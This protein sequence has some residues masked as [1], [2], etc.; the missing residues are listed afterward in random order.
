MRKSLFV[1][2]VFLLTASQALATSSVWKIQKGTSVFYLG[3]T[4]HLLRPTDFPPPKEFFQAFKASSIIVFETDIGKLK[5]PSMQQ[6][7]M[8][9]A[10]Y[11]DGSTL[12]NHISAATYQ[13]LK[14][15][16]ASHH[17][18]L[19][20]LMQYKP[21]ILAFTITFVELAKLGVTPEGVDTY[22]Y[23]LAQHDGKKVEGLETVER[24]IQLV[25]NMGQGNQDSFLLHTLEDMK[26]TAKRYDSMVDAWKK[27][28]V[29]KLDAS[30]IEDFRSQTPKLYRQ[31]LVYR[32][33]KWLPRIEALAKTPQTEFILVGVAHLV[34]PDGLL[35]ALQ[36][37]GYTIEPVQT[38]KPGRSRHVDR[39]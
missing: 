28:D 31:L 1:I 14:Q 13:R 33:R 6:K 15:Y 36:R 16:C 23:Q 27:G 29:A 20:R 5:E 39:G 38:P 7:M 11:T 2:F 10:S 21:S 26:S 9:E 32:N 19:D 37:Q 12:K 22:F 24:Q 34:G 35:Q 4:C 8:R 30:M 25:A 17:I 3:G 18:P